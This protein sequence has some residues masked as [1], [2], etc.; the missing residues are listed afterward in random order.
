MKSSLVYSLPK[1]V[2][3][4][5]KKQIELSKELQES[6]KKN[7][8]QMNS[9][10]TKFSNQEQF[11]VCHAKYEDGVLH[12]DLALTDYA[13]YLFT[14][15]N[16]QIDNPCISVAA[17]CI[18]ETSDKYLVVA[19][20]HASTSLAG[21]LKFIG[22]AISKDDLTNDNFDLEK[23]ARRELLEEVGIPLTFDDEDSQENKNLLL[24]R[25]GVN[26]YN[27]LF[28]VK[29]SLSKTKFYSFFEKYNNALKEK[30]ENELEDIVFIRNEPDSI[31]EFLNS[32]T[33]DSVEYFD[34][35]LK[36]IAKV[37]KPGNIIETLKAMGRI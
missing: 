20:M 35:C 30:G 4:Y 6:I 12:F 18:V 31:I 17:N 10:A 9:G 13:H 23:A 3:K 7:F 33:F 21:K 29:S 22:G 15:K 27:N 8:Q 36:V 28:Y 19:K 16:P 5:S 1:S 32:N 14:M 37:I 24:T 26:F 25:P 2:Y 11:S 34:D